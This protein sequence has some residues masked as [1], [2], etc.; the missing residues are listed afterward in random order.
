MKLVTLSQFL[1]LD[2]VNNI[3]GFSGV[4]ARQVTQPLCP[5]KIPLNCKDNSDA[6]FYDT[7][8]SWR[9]EL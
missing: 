6:I 4:V 8:F 3:S 1:P 9:M 5:F 2:P 7:G